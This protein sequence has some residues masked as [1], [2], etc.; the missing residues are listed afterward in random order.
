MTPQPVRQSPSR[1]VMASPD[2]ARE[3][4]EDPQL[5]AQF[6]PRALPRSMKT[7]LGVRYANLFPMPVSAEPRNQRMSANWRL[8]HSAASR[9]IW[10]LCL[11]TTDAGTNRAH[12]LPRS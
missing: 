11:R 8:N 10:P 9:V 2:A 7:C 4:R 12:C 3:L 5:P 6:P 1:G